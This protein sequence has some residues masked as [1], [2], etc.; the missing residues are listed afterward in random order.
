MGQAELQKKQYTI[1]EWLALEQAE[2]VRYEYH[3]GEVFAMAGGT[4]NHGRISGNAYFLIE[5]NFRN[6]EKNCETF[7]SDIKVEVKLDGRYVYPDTLAVCGD[8]ERSKKTSGSITNPVLVVEVVSESSGD[9]DRGDKYRYYKRLPS[10]KEYL[11]LDQKKPV[12][13][14][15]RR[16]GSG[17]IFSTLDYEGMEVEMELTSIDLKLKLGAFYRNVDFN[18]VE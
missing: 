5:E 17:D 2:G 18:E 16:N 13:I 1:E 14:L 4:I 15:H 11:I 9:Y 10:V 7:T 12:A 6:K 8:V 3:F